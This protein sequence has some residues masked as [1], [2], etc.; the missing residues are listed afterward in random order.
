MF[1]DAVR[2]ILSP[3]TGTA[4][5]AAVGLPTPNSKDKLSR[6]SGESEQRN[7]GIYIK[8]FFAIVYPSHWDPFL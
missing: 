4:L 7:T 1:C 3:L 5:C 8:Y 2:D 6:R